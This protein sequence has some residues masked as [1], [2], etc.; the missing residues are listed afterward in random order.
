MSYNAPGSRVVVYTLSPPATWTT[1][2]SIGGVTFNAGDRLGARAFPDGT[3]QVFRNG[4]LLGSVSVAGWPY[5]ALGGHIGVSCVGATTTRFESFGGGSVSGF[6]SVVD[7]DRSPE[8]L[9]RLLE[10]SSPYPNPA[11]GGVA[12]SLSLPRETAVSMRVLD[13]M[14]RQVW[15]APE[16]N[17]GAGRW[18]LTWDGRGAGGPV[19][20]GMYLVRVRAGEAAFSRRCVIVR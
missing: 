11:H 9:P 12:L 17:F 16:R 5:A 1:C 8:P 6:G 4:V 19:R 14:G 15:S 10:L 2:G 3:V 20:P 7:A 18:T 13:I